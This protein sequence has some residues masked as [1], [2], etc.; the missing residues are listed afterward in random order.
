MPNYFYMYYSI[1]LLV[2][3]YFNYVLIFFNNFSLLFTL[4]LSL[5]LSLYIYIYIYIYEMG[6]SY[7]WCNSIRITPFLS[8][9][10]SKDR[11]VK[12]KTLLSIIISF[13]IYQINSIHIISLLIKCFLCLFFSLL[14]NFFNFHCN[15]FFYAIP[16]TFLVSTISIFLCFSY[17]CQFFLH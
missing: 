13:N 11:T 4:S 15:S 14:I 8:H 12:K 7:T 2:K 10:F 1:L 9:K 5:S 17:F 3:V 6:S 16:S